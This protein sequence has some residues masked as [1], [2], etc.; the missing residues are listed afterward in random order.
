M[1]DNKVLADPA[2]AI[3]PVHDGRHVLADKPMARES[4]PYIVVLPDHQIAFFT[5]TWVTKDG[6]AGAALAMFGPGVGPDPIQQRLPDRPVP[7]DMGFDNW[8]IDGFRMEQDLLFDKAHVH[9]ETPEAT[10]D[11]SFE[12]YH[13]PYAYGADP[14]GCPSY[15]A[16]NRI[17]Q[18]GKVKGTLTLGGRVIE[19]EGTGHR[20][21]SWGRR[22][23]VAMQQYEWFVGQVGDEI[24]VHFWNLKA[25][26]K[27]EVRGYV[28]KDGLMALVDTVDV[29][30]NYDDQFWQQSYTA[31]VV[32]KAG[33]T[34]EIS[35]EVYAHYTLVPDPNLMLNES[36]GRSMIDGK[37]GVGWMECAW[38]TTYL[39]HI[40][41]NGPY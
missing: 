2:M 21:H 35:T 15:C 36:A 22:D 10:V 40:K 34:T 4:I 23:W 12:A 27:S 8:Q 30:V 33:R 39:D 17:E 7:A 41:A 3:D 37:A 9:W 31:I 28:Y 1:F 32:D 19:F 16:D 24:S 26:G 18:A 38:P 29:N 20:D 14:R 5:Y 6:A 13:P 25:L 11:F